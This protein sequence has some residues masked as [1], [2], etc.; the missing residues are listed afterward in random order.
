MCV[1]LCVG[2]LGGII[3]SS[4]QRQSEWFEFISCQT[5]GNGKENKHND[6]IAEDFYDRNR[7]E[8]EWKT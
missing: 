5:E 2:D 6:G 4:L 1:K 7:E 8:K 3:F